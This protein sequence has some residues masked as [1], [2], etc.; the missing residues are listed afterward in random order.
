M[1]C[2]CAV[3]QTC[4]IHTLHK[5]LQPA[6]FFD[7]VGIA[8]VAATAGAAAGMQVVLGSRILEMHAALR[9]LLCTEAFPKHMPCC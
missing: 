4:Q 8:A 2:R 5:V 6:P 3:S 9:A 1:S 7:F